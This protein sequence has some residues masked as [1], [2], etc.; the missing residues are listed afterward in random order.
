MKRSEML[1]RRC[2]ENNKSTQLGVGTLIIRFGGASYP[3][4]LVK[5]TTTL[6]ADQQRCWPPEPSVVKIGD[7]NMCHAARIR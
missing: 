5:T 1:L 3:I 7:Y 6:W 2:Y 4:S